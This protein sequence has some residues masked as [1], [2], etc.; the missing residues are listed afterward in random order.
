M[1]DVLDEARKAVQARL[2]EIRQETEP[3]ERAIRSLRGPSDAKPKRFAAT[4]RKRARV[5][6]KRLSRAERH[7]QLAAYAKKHSTATNGEI[8]KALGVSAAYVSRMISTDKGLKRSNGKLI[9][10]S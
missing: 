8:A 1:P 6:K 10:K 9:V 5:R 7:D 3:L 2:A 4:S